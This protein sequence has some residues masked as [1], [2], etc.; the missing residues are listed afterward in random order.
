MISQN[1][2]NI[3]YVLIFNTYMSCIRIW[4]RVHK[5][6]TAPHIAAEAMLHRLT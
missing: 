1:A 4:R 5:V 2:I 3:A 6:Y